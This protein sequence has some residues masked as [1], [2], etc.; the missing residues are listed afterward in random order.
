MHDEIPKLTAEDRE[1]SL[2][3]L[4]LWWIETFTVV[5]RG[6]AIGQQKQWSDEAARWLVN[7]YALDKKGRRRFSEAFLSRPKGWD[8][9][10]KGAGIGMFE[11]LGPCRF[12]GWAKGGETYTFLG[13]TYVYRAGE[14]MG[15]PVQSP[16][17]LC[18]ATAEKQTGNV[19]DSIYFNCSEGPLAALQ[20]VG[21]DVAKTRIGL[22]EGGEIIPSSSGAASKDGGL[23]TFVVADEVHLYTSRQLKS[24]YDTV[25]RNLPKRS[26]DADPWMLLTTTMYRP[27]EESVAEDIYKYAHALRE[28]KVRHRAGLY[29]DHRYS[30]L[31][32]QEFSDEKKLRL[33]LFEAYGSVGKSLDKHTYVF[34]PDGK[35]MPLLEG[36]VTEDGYP[37]SACEPGPS[38]EGW[39]STDA[40]MTEIYKP[41][42]D[43]GDMTRYYMNN[44]SSVDDAWIDEQTIQA[45]MVHVDEANQAAQNGTL[46][47]LWQDYVSEDDPIT[48]GFDGSVS[49]DSTALVG[50]RVRDGML[51]LIKLEQAPDGPEKKTWRVDRDA[52]DGRA[53]YMFEHYNVVGC[54]ADAAFFE[55][56]IAGWETDYPQCAR[57]VPRT[58]AEKMRFYTNAWHQ[59]MFKGLSDMRTAFSYDM[60]SVPPQ[61]DP[62][63]GNVELL[64]DPRLVDHFRNTRRRDRSFGYLVFKETPNS[65]KKIDAAMAGILAFMARQKYLT[66]D[67]VDEDDDFFIPTRVY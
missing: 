51:F 48:L 40:L 31:T 47:S 23:E 38:P 3:W 30:N 67:V 10:G 27:G 34:Q 53:R 25:S 44:L 35:M 19:Y 42:S 9:S 60:R 32:A 49:D 17:I 12:A 4:A 6:G 64:A 18:L 58:N 54:F 14:P 29:F 13:K 36:D 33:A 63:A 61:D 20:G 39:V 7:C 26:L 2:G 15:K 43:P 50:C 62:V 45:H 65:A 52:F 59:D 28:G 41:S 66:L 11:A 24:M 8:K 57:V 37:A 46:D 5:G 22:P 1:K 16:E 56:M 21:L 55:S